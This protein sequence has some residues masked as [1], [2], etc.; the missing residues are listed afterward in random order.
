MDTSSLPDSQVSALPD[1]QAAI[2]RRA[3]EIYIQNGR[4]PGRDLENW[5]QA[6]EEV[7]R[8]LAN[9]TGNPAKP[10]LGLTGGKRT[11]VVVR[12]NG[13]QYIGEYSPEMAAGYTPGEFGSGAP[14]RVRFAGDKMFLTRPNGSELETTIVRKLG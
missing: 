5:A 9:A 10:E 8:E 6:E 4:I 11:A 2:R 14:V 1:L 12:V 13:T 3:E 7:T